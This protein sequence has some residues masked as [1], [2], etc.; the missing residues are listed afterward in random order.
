M[1][2]DQMEHFTHDDLPFRKPAMIRG[3]YL[4]FIGAV[5]LW[6]LTALF[7]VAW[8]RAPK[9]GF[10]IVGMLGLENSP[11]EERLYAILYTAALAGTSAF[12]W[13]CTKKPWVLLR[14]LT[15]LGAGSVLAMTLYSVIRSW[16]FDFRP[17]FYEYYVGEA[18]T[19]LAA[20]FVTVGAMTPLLQF[21]P[22]QQANS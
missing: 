4:F 9:G 10:A 6:F 2:L 14:C 5:W 17:S 19:C 15:G 18:V 12:A 1:L 16:M 22:S 11:G 13:I 3:R 7:L 8:L 21:R 20:I